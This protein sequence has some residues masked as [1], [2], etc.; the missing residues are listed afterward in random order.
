MGANFFS[1]RF[2]TSP[3]L[4]FVEFRFKTKYYAK[5]TERHKAAEKSEVKSSGPE[6]TSSHFHRLHAVESLRVAK[7]VYCISMILSSGFPQKNDSPVAFFL[8]K[9]TFFIQEKTK[10]N[11]KKQKKTEKRNRPPLRRPWH[12]RKA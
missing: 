12:P 9:K 8:D 2:S 7:W 3:R 4:F 10:K 1:F 5:N 6:H 11:K